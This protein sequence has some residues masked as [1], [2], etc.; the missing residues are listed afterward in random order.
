MLVNETMAKL[1]KFEQIHNEV[2]VIAEEVNDFAGMINKLNTEFF[3]NQNFETFLDFFTGLFQFLDVKII[4][5]LAVVMNV[6]EIVTQY[7][8]F[9]VNEFY[10]TTKKINDFITDPEFE[11]WAKILHMAIDCQKQVYS[12]TPVSLYL[13]LV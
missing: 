8:D 12:Q 3:E 7:P 9:D 4:L 5:S 6:D 2:G 11:N 1:E 10:L 13:V